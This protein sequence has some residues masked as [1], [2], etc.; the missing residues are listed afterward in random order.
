[1]AYKNNRLLRRLDHFL[2]LVVVSNNVSKYYIPNFRLNE[3]FLC[4]MLQIHYVLQ[5]IE[6][7][8]LNLNYEWSGASFINIAYVQNIPQTMRAPLS[9][10]KLP[11]IKT[12]LR[13]RMSL[14]PRKL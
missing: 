4:S 8:G 1:M 14:A 10:Q 7:Q 13:V 12:E 6:Q 3:S 2:L 11:F 9:P 5:L